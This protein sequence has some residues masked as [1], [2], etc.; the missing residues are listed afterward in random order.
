MGLF[1]RKSLR[2]GPL[3]INLSKS[4]IGVSAGVK[5][6][7]VGTGPRGSY[8]SGG[9]HGIYY[10]RSLGHAH[11]RPITNALSERSI[12]VRPTRKVFRTLPL[13]VVLSLVAVV[14]VVG[15][16]AAQVTVAILAN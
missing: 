4:G 2:L 1:F 8:V 10:R 7:R 11:Q 5:G 14:V 6:L 12:V 3:R 16:G 15:A 9:R 13:V